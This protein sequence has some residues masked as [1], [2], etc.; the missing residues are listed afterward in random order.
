MQEIPIT[1]RIAGQ[2]LWRHNMLANRITVGVI[3]I[4]GLCAWLVT[5]WLNIPYTA[6]L[7]QHG[8]TIVIGFALLHFMLVNLL[9]IR[10]IFKKPF[11]QFRLA[12]LVREDTRDEIYHSNH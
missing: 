12:V 8:V 4:A 2:I 10:S 5:Y 3:V 6:W 1:W 9:A 7:K 11:R